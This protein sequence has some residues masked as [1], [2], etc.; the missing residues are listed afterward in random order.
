MFPDY[1]VFLVSIPQMVRLRVCT[2]YPSWGQV[3][4]SI[5]QMVRLRDNSGG[6]DREGDCSFNSTNGTIKR[7]N[8]M[9]GKSW[10]Y[11][12]QFHKWYD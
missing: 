9:N 3:P 2:F 7:L 6:A 11:L 8:L 10:D 12:F 5:P 4:V 1:D